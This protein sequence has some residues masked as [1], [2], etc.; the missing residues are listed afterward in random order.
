MS[1]IVD[2]SM[3]ASFRA[4]I[5]RPEHGHRTHGMEARESASLADPKSGARGRFFVTPH[6]VE[7]YRERFRQTVGYRTALRELILITS[8]AKRVG[9]T[10]DGRGE[11]WRGPRIGAKSKQDRRS[12]LRFVVANGERGELPQVVTVLAPRSA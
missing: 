3:I 12:R 9:T 7:R 8:A 10:H 11:I 6:A 5:F 1:E 2:E 4:A